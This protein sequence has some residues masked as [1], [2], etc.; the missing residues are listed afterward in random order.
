MADSKEVKKLT[1]GQQKMIARKVDDVHE[2]RLWPAICNV[3][4]VFECLPL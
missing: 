4:P 2:A 1:S 3:H